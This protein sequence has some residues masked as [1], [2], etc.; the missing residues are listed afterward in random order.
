MGIAAN[1]LKDLIIRPTL[2]YLDQQE[3]GYEELLV[4]TAAQESSLAFHCQCERTGGLG[5]YRI[6]AGKHREIW[7]KVLIKNPEIASRIRGLASQQ[8]FLLAPHQELVTNLSYATAI[9]W[10]IYQ[11]H[12]AN[13]MQDLSTM[14]RLWSQYF[15]NGTGDERDAGGFISRYR[16]LVVPDSRIHVA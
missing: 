8:Q 6:T 9:A 16:Q 13:L 2:Q 11:C 10:A 1:E 4:A 12:E 15:D 7:D 14:A 5:I 3:I